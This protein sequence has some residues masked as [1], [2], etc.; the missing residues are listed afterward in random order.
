MRQFTLR[1]L[2]ERSHAKPAETR[3]PLDWFRVK[4]AV[5]AGGAALLLAALVITVMAVWPHPQ[6][7]TPLKAAI[8]DQLAL[9]DPNP[10]FVKEATRELEDAGYRVDYVPPEAV[11]VDFYRALPKKGYHLIILRSH[12]SSARSQ[13]VP[14]AVGGVTPFLAD[15]IV[16]VC[17]N[18]GTGSST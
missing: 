12:S 4:I 16:S 9:T 6:G 5:V 3:Y 13:R 14:V 8:I 10:A 17:L 7:A 1:R 15:V 2:F 11:T 18:P